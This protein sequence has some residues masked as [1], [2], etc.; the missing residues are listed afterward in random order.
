MSETVEAIAYMEDTKGMFEVT[1]CYDTTE[2]DG[3]TFYFREVEDARK[4]VAALMDGKWANVLI[5]WWPGDERVLVNPAHV[6]NISVCV[7]SQ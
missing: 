5:K 2:N 7:A 3:R 1:I 6:T 4:I